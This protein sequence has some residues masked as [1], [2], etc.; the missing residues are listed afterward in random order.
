VRNEFEVKGEEDVINCGNEAVRILA[1][2]DEEKSASKKRYWS[3]S[4]R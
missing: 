3:R 1:E 2:M 4:V